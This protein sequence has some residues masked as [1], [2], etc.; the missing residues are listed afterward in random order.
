VAAGRF[1]LL[2]AFLSVPS[3]IQEAG[4]NQLSR[5][6]ELAVAQSAR[7]T[8]YARQW[9]NGAAAQDVVQEALVALLSCRQAPDDPVAWMY[10]VI[11]HRAIDAA[12]SES[13]RRRREDQVAR[14]RSVWF[15]TDA[16]A[17]L[18]AES[19]Q[20][21]LEQ[22]PC[23]LREIV[24]LRLWGEL[25]FVQIAAI[26]G[27]SVGTAHQRFSESLRQLRVMMEKSHSG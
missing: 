15:E 16:S 12:R 14:E 9:L 20:K 26:A 18:D 17:A 2:K 11:R 7:L 3:S 13:R 8:L 23:E 27:V 24:V 4:M 1:V 5:S 25:G 19:A 22:L 10:T 6:A 21:A